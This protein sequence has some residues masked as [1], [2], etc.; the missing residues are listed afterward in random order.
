MKEIQIT[1]KLL[2]LLI[3][4]SI[5]AM[6]SSCRA[7][8]SSSAKKEETKKESM[9][10]KDTTSTLSEVWIEEV[11]EHIPVLSDCADTSTVLGLSIGSTLKKITRRTYSRQKE[12]KKTEVEAASE[13]K[14]VNIKKETEKVP[15]PIVPFP[16]W[17]WLVAIGAIALWVHQIKKS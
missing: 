7:T 17:I 4:L 6:V 10:L 13:A 3:L 12:S 16:W 9:V 15:P 8:K 5:L 11:E 14:T 1:Q 2:Y